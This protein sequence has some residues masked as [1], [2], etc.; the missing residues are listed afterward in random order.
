MKPIGIGMIGT[1][2]M[3]TAHTYGYSHS[4]QYTSDGTCARLVAVASRDA[5][6]GRGFADEFGYEKV[7]QDWKELVRDDEV[8]A[9]SICTPNALHY[10]QA[11]EVILAG[12][13]VYVEKPMTITV[14]QA[15]D[16]VNLA[17]KHGVV[18]QVVF[19]TRF[20]PAVMRAKS[21]IDEGFCGRL[22]CLR[23]VMLHSGL[24]DTS[25]R[26]SWRLD[27]KL[28][29]SG[30]LFDLGSHI[31]DLAM[32]LCGDIESIYCRTKTHHKQRL[33]E[34]GNSVEVT[35]DDAAWMTVQLAGGVVGTLEASKLATGVESEVKLEIHGENG[36]IFI[37]ANSPYKLTV[38]DNTPPKE[39][40]KRVDIDITGQFP[41]P[42]MDLPQQSSNKSLIHYH[43]RSVLAFLQSINTGKQ[44]SPSLA[45]GLHVQRVMEA[46]YRSAGLDKGVA[47]E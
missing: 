42:T 20:S 41:E 21:L 35:T 30:V 47:I 24:V 28:T 44:P 2:F 45:D 23:G 40:R 46:A 9:V 4:Q 32:Y 27:P 8:Q 10:E 11:R 14:E 29:G 37:D 12:K 34:D 36:A 18:G 38:F 39:E 1:G 6:R 17:E 19:N 22:I 5:G 13:H 25:R 43:A 16:L 7:Y 33:D 3:A 31:I 15:E 26:I